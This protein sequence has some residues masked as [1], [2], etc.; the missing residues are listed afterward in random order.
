[1]QILSTQNDRFALNYKWHLIASNKV[2]LLAQIKAN[3]WCSSLFQGLLKLNR[4]S[5]FFFEYM[6]LIKSRGQTKWAHNECV[7]NNCVAF[8]ISQDYTTQYTSS[9]TRC[10]LLILSLKE[11]RQYLE[12]DGIPKIDEANLSM[13]HSDN[14]HFRLASSLKNKSK[15][16]DEFV[17]FSHV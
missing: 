17:A 2:A 6:S 4:A 5:S 10:T 15:K 3:D 14:K 8:N 1:V 12:S 13:S 9:C 16:R 11:T 7:D